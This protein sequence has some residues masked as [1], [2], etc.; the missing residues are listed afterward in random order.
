LG[1]EK[2]EGAAADPLAATVTSD[3]ELAK[4]NQF[5]L[6]PEERVGDDGTV[7]L[8]DHRA[9][10]AGEPAAHPPFEF[11]HAHPIAVSLVL[12]ELMVQLGEERAVVQ[13]GRPEIHGGVRRTGAFTPGG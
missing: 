9:I 12:D 6:F 4:V 10:L 3:E 1:A 8:V 2:L 11:R 13:S 7:L 5:G